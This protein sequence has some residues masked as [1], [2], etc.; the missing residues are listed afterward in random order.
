MSWDDLRV[1]LALHRE[2]TVA[3]A[4]RALGVSRSTVLRRWA[5]LEAATTTLFERT[6]EGVVLTGAGERLLPSAERVEGE[7]LAAERAI[8]GADEGLRGSLEV[9]LFDIAGP[10][11]A[12]AFQE[13]MEA[14]PEMD[15]RLVSSDR[16]RSLRRREADLAI[17]GTD[18]PSPELFGRKIG[19]PSTG[20]STTWTA[21]SSGTTSPS[22]APP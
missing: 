22:S 21:R 14:H 9:T 11:L 13:L 6:P 10:L 3:G 19:R 15:L 16:L 1:F 2:G 8:A 4:A 12:P 17:R 7:A 20:A 5:A 18:A